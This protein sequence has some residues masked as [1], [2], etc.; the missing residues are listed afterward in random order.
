M[1]KLDNI[2]FAERVLT[3]ALVAA[4]IQPGPSQPARLR[5]IV[6][7]TLPEIA[8]EL[9]LEIAPVSLDRGVYRGICLGIHGYQALVK[10]RYKGA[11]IVDLSVVADGHD[12]PRLGDVLHLEM[13]AGKIK[14]TFV[15]Q[16]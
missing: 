11:M 7:K 13:S 12:M 16:R 5:E 10:H 2:R 8:Q 1:S 4:G 3:N 9:Q 6:V 14:F 15:N